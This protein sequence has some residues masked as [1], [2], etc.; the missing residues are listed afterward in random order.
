MKNYLRPLNPFY[1]YTI[2]QKGGEMKNDK[3]IM[4]EPA[5]LK[6]LAKREHE[7]RLKE[8]SLNARENI[9][10]EM[11][12]VNDM[13]HKELMVYAE[14]LE[15]LEDRNDKHFCFNVLITVAN[16]AVAVLNAVLL[17]GFLS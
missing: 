11:K 5:Q 8:D 13:F 14:D 1:G 4:I 6:K 7:V 2:E 3:Y 17:W 16:V 12:F 15:E 10:N 9:V